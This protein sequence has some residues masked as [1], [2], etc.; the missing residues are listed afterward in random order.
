MSNRKNNS[1]DVEQKRGFTQFVLYLVVALA[2]L[3][4]PYFLDALK[5]AASI[6]LY[7]CGTLLFCIVTIYMHNRNRVAFTSVLFF[8]LLFVIHPLLR[9]QER[10]LAINFTGVTHAV[11]V[12]IYFTVVLSCRRLRAVV[13]WLRGGRIDIVTVAL[14]VMMIALSAA[15]LVVWV[16]LLKP[17]LGRFITSVPPWNMPILIVGGVGFAVSNALV[18]EFIFRGVLWDGLK[19]ACNKPPAVLLIQAAVFGGWH[20]RGF[21]GGAVGVSM[22][23]AWGVFLGLVRQRSRGMVAPLITHFFADLTIFFILLA[24]V[25]R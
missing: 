18:E 5:T 23:F 13:S 11:P 8:L 22:V 10:M 9:Y 25:K 21:P 16:L 7:I 24:I 12:L 14:M 1:E 20:F 3:F 19:G 17:D 4:S 15:G 6:V 2:A